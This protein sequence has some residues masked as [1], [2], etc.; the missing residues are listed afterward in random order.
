MAC[1]SVITSLLLPCLRFP[2]A[3]I[4]F[5]VRSNTVSF[6]CMKVTNLSLHEKSGNY[7]NIDV[8]PLL[9]KLLTTESLLSLSMLIN[10]LL[11]VY[12]RVYFC[13]C[14]YEPFLSVSLL[15]VMDGR[16]CFL[17]VFAGI[18]LAV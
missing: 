7:F 12:A 9:R 18:L 14:V 10:A 3:A 6:F 2:I 13:V 17:C 5:S 15:V 11:C 8:S 16:M 4:I 1:H